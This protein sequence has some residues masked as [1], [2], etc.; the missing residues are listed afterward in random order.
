MLS[1][2]S[3]RFL[4]LGCG[5]A[6]ERRSSTKATLTLA[7]APELVSRAGCSEFAEARHGGRAAWALD[8]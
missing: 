7:S 6:E 8:G 2:R 3:A 1:M 5:Q 4:D